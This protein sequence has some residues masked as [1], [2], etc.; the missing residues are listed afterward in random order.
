MLEQQQGQ[1]VAGLREL[2]SRCL[3]KEGWLGAPLNEAQNGHPLTHDILERLDL[4]QTSSDGS[5]NYE[6]F[7]EDT[8]KLQ[9][10]LIRQGAQYANRR[11]SISSESEHGPI[12]SSGSSAGSTPMASMEKPVPYLESLHHRHPPTPPMT[13][14]YLVQ[15]QISPAKRGPSSMVS[16][17]FTGALNPLDLSMPADTDFGFKNNIYP[18][19]EQPNPPDGYY[20]YDLTPDISMMLQPPLEPWVNEEAEFSQFLSTAR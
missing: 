16:P 9:M 6:E 14:P 2:Y 5:P 12:S 4:L 15:A 20:G 13:S 18:G 8:Q 1:L 17:V 19:Y 7:E 10:K 11:G 3:K